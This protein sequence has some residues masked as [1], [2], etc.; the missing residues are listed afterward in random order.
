MRNLLLAGVALG[1]TAFSVPGLATPLAGKSISSLTV[2][3]STYTVNFFD[4]ALSAVPIPQNTF[5]T[6]V[7]ANNA[8]AAIVSSSSYTTLIATANTVQGTYYKGLIV[9]YSLTYG[10]APLQYNGAV[11]ASTSNGNLPLYYSPSEDP[12]TN[13][14]YTVVGYAIAQF[15][16]ASVPEPA[17]I[18]VVAL[19]LFSLGWARRRFR[20]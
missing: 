19:G 6:F 7:A 14:D 17:S 11:G 10:P 15:I 3:G 20:I 9:P 4:S 2:D 8:I 5:T 18:A 13:G 12:N 16:P 1:V